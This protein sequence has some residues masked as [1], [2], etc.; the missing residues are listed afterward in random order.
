MKDRMFSQVMIEDIC[1]T[2][3]ISKVT[4]FKF[5]QRKEDLLIYYM[6]VW[7]TERMIE[8]EQE[9]KKD[10]RHSAICCPRLLRSIK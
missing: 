2:A 3:E 7:L 4:F 5:Y 1:K 9:D 8:I 6:R 10:F